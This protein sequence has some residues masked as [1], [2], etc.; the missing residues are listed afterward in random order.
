MR[1]LEAVD[2]LD[3]EC[4]ELLAELGLGPIDFDI[5]SAL[6]FLVE[7][8]VLLPPGEP[9]QGEPTNAS[10]NGNWEFAKGVF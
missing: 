4:E 7:S 10:E 9:G 8:K 3:R 6:R 5:Q 1:S 2:T